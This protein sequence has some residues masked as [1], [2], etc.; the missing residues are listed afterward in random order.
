M[1]TPLK[2]PLSRRRF[3]VRPFQRRL[4]LFQA[5]YFGLLT[6]GLY[7]VF[8]APL[9]SAVQD[10]SAPSQERVGSAWA[11]IHFDRTALPI[12]IPLVFVLFA[13]SILVS[14]R[15]AGP[16]YRFGIVLRE[17]ASGNLTHRF[18]IRP[19]DYL[20]EEAAELQRALT[21]LRERLVAIRGDTRELRQVIERM[22]PANSPC[23]A[24]E[25][26]AR[27]ETRLEGFVLDV[28]EEATGKDGRLAA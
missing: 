2:V 11:L 15:I 26:L 20:H 10:P 7:F 18:R 14:H 24:R 3:L 6:A 21:S 13:H 1:G 27:L 17:M 16:L 25:A 4:I 28:P 12:L 5:L 9:F 22:A 23:A 8:L 19:R